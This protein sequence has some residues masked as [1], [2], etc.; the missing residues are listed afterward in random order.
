MEEKKD[1]KISISTFFLI[2]AIV[3][4]IV[5]TYFIYNL[6]IEKVANLNSEINSLKNTVNKLQEQSNSS[7]NNENNVDYNK[8]IL[9]E[10]AYSEGATGYVYE[11]K[12]DGTII[13]TDEISTSKGKY[14]TIGENQ[15]Q[16]TLTERTTVNTDSNK[17]KIEKINESYQINVIDKNN[18]NIIGENNGEKFNFKITKLEIN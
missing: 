18:L 15:V 8:E 17:T 13:E 4:I 14:K 10:G 1:I 11:F 16:V 7:T 9:L 5:M 12:T 2:L 3:V 6:N